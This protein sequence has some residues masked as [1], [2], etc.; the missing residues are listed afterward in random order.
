MIP[1]EIRDAVSEGEVVEVAVAFVGD[2]VV[3]DA[4][5]L[6]DANRSPKRK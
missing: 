3:G 1:T 6:D 4:D 2:V 5:V